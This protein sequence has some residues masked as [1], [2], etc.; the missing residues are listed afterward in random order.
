M[1]VLYHLLVP[2]ATT[3]TSGTTQSPAGGG[4]GAGGCPPF[5]ASTCDMSCVAMDSSGCLSCNCPT[6][7]GD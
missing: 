4:Q 6:S 7:T 1:N 5:D 2:P 3:V